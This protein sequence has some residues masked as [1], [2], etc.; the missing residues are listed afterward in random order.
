MSHTLAYRRSATA[1]EIE[2]FWADGVVHLPAILPVDWIAPAFLVTLV[3]FPAG[4]VP[5]GKTASGLP[6]GLQIVGPR[7]SEPQILGLAKLV[8]R[9]NPIGWPT[10]A[11]S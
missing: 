1:A 7:F 4:S 10:H 8:Q 3:G 6:V 5:G 9:V 11:K 2:Q